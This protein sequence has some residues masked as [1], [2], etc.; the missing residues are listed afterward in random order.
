MKDGYEKEFLYASQGRK[1][2][3][4]YFRSFKFGC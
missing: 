2:E 3:V 1:K 4:S